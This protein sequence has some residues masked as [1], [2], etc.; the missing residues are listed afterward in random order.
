MKKTLVLFITIF[1]IIFTSI[2]NIA[3]SKGLPKINAITTFAPEVP[4][5]VNRNYSAYVIVNF[6]A[7]EVVKELADG[8]KYNFWTFDG[9]VPGKFVRVRQGDTVEFNLHNNK[10]SKVPHNIDIHAVS[11]PGGGAAVSNTAPGHTSVFTFKALNP[12]VFIYHCATP[13]VPLHIANGMYGLVYVEPFKALPAVD[14]EYYLVQSEFYTVNPYGEKGLQMFSQEKALKETPDYVVFNGRVGSLVDNKSLTSDVGDTV[15][16]F[17]GNAGPNL[18]SSFHIIGIIFDKVYTEG[19]SIPNRNV[20]T[21]ILPAGGAAI[22]EFNTPVPGTYVI[23]DHAIFRA[24]NKGCVGLL[25]VVGQEN[26]EV[27]SAR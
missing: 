16:M 11:G 8:V 22:A 21:T 4:P 17:L 18:I 10:S 2:G 6:E 3:I 13:P 23:V 27:Y 25:K 7:L 24:F 9:A 20:Q 19:G 12:G 26:R 15:R 5:A 14:K 1:T